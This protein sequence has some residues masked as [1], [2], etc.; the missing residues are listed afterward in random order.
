MSKTGD[1]EQTDADILQCKADILRARDIIP[2]YKKKPYQDT[3]PTE[4]TASTSKDAKQGKTKIPKFDLAEDIMAE[5]RKITAV[6]RKAPAEKAKVQSQE[7]EIESISHII[8]Q[9]TPTSS[10]QKQIIAEIV[11]RDIERLCR[12]NTERPWTKFQEHNKD[13]K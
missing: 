4:E 9:S 5:H 11:A 7:P 13:A 2:S 12:G 3:Q 1:N 8:E 10:E 6:K